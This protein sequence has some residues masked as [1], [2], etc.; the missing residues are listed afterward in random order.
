MENTS[1]GMR[2]YA[3]RLSELD[4]TLSEQVQAGDLTVRQ[5]YR[6]LEAQGRGA[7]IP[8][9]FRTDSASRRESLTRRLRSTAKLLMAEGVDAEAILQE[10]QAATK[11][12]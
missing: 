7:E 1:Y 6:E 12:A 8:K 10:A 11:A 3:S 5:A 9:M 2:Y 4:A